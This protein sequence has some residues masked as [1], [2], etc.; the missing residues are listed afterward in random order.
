M[1]KSHGNQELDRWEE[2]LNEQIITIQNC[3]NEKNLNSCFVCEALLD[4]PVRKE[5]IKA[6]YE[7]M[8]KAAYATQTR[9]LGTNQKQINTLLSQTTNDPL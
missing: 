6:V 4:C 5:Y 7:S 9:S 3:Q 2:A 8:N 1:A